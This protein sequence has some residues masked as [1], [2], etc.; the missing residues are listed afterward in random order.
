M[1]MGMG[2]ID[3]M[4]LR[5]RFRIFGLDWTSIL[6]QQQQLLRLS[7]SRMTRKKKVGSGPRGK[8]NTSRKSTGSSRQTTNFR[9][10]F[11]AQ[12][13]PH[14][15]LLE[16]A[17]STGHRRTDW[18]PQTKLRYT[19]VNFVTGGLHIPT[20]EDNEIQ[21]GQVN[22]DGAE[23]DMEQ[24]SGHSGNAA[25]LVPQA[26]PHVPEKPGP[27][28]S[29][30]LFIVDTQGQ[31]PA[32]KQRSAPMVR[33]PS[34]SGSASSDEEVIFAGRRPQA[35]PVAVSAPREVP[36]T[37]TPASY[38]PARIVE[39]PVLVEAPRPSARP[40][41]SAT[42]TQSSLFSRASNNAVGT[43]GI[44][45]LSSDAVTTNSRPSWDDTSV[46]WVHRSK[47]G[48][49]WSVPKLKPKITKD[50]VRRSYILPGAKDEESSEEEDEEEQI[51]RDYIE[52]MQSQDASSHN[53]AFLEYRELDVQL[54]NSS[55]STNFK[56]SMI[57]AS[58]LEDK[59]TSEDE[60]G[61]RVNLSK[62]KAPML[63]GSDSENDSSEEDEDDDEDDEDDDIDEDD[64]SIL[65]NADLEQRFQDSI[66]DEVLARLLAKQE[67]LGLNTEELVLLDDEA[68][69]PFN[70]RKEAKIYNRNTPRKARRVSGSFP[71]ASLMADV[72]EQDPYGGFDIMNFDRPSLRTKNKG[73]RAQLSVDLSDSDLQETL[74]SSWQHDR[75]KKRARKAEREILRMQ[76]LLGRKK[77]GKANLSDVYQE[78]MSTGDLMEVFRAFLESDAQEQ[79][80]PP[81]DKIRRKKVHELAK[82]FEMSSKSKGTKQNRFPLLIKT[83]RT[84]KWDASLFYAR[85]KDMNAGYFPRL[86]AQLRSKT[87]GSRGSRRSAGGGG[88]APGTKYRDGDI[89]GAAAPELG[90]GNR[91]HA[92]LM[93]LGWAQGDALG[94]VDNKGILQPISH[95]VKNSKAGLG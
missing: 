16:E 3:D 22:N 41:H 47:P 84:Q 46:E 90:V 68:I 5:V 29:D 36:A 95:V 42:T 91:G 13:P 40:L 63:N 59:D 49:G 89:V 31:K 78:G 45:R 82:A 34:P 51:M 39:D 1:C 70:I 32:F 75:E 79:A 27:V 6:H 48:I 2:I 66:D 77:K 71:S 26:S 81:M 15:S 58:G 62:G 23:A 74:E 19:K 11:A 44:S 12:D 57:E 9:D 54:A 37:Q 8:P 61:N 18:T 17:R 50:P 24:L 87:P 53:A 83:Q 4:H 56:S 65:D 43:S 93:K 67:E 64:D 86:D 73:K 33:S 21:D 60:Q 20:E 30:G 92:M 52:N 7:K 28:A 69:N 35:N 38:L 72:L 94:A 10:H 76:G 85:S 14:F 80:L 25:A 88:N 55:I